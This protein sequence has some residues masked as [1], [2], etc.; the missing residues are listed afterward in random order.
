[1]SYINVELL[2]YVLLQ[3]VF[4]VEY[5]P[6]FDTA[7]ETLVCEFFTRLEELLPVP[8]FKQVNKENNTLPGSISA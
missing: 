2:I 7:L 8:D 4:P 3:N 6:D 5:G 1:M